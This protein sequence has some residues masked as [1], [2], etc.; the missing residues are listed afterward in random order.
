MKN[1]EKL[2]CNVMSPRLVVSCGKGGS[3]NYRDKLL[4][5]WYG[6]EEVIF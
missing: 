2:R 3:Y 5:D 1:N 4:I 6:L